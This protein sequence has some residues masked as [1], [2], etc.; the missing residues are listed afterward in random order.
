[1]PLSLAD[2]SHRLIEAARA[3]G[4]DAA[5]AVA[6]SGSTV[7]VDVRG[8]ALEEAQRSEQIDIGLRAFVGQKQASV[9][10][11]DTSERTI[12]EL[13]ARVVAMASEAPEDP[14]AGL[15]LPSQLA[16]NIDQSSLD[17]VDKAPEPDPSWLEEQAR[18]AEHAALAQRGVSQVQSA[19]AQYGHRQMHLA[20]T[21]GF[22]A[23][24][25]RTATTIS[26]VA[27]SGSGTGMERDY[28]Y[29]SRCHLEDL[30]S[31]SVI[32]TLAGQ[33]AVALIGSRKP[34][35]GTFPVLFDERISS[36][37]IG[38]LLQAS[39]GAAIA[40]GSS[41]LLGK[42]GQQVLPEGIDLIE[43]PHRLRIAGS[44]LFDG[45]GL[46]TVRRKI[47]D[48]GVLTGWALDLAT[49][50]KLGL[51]S[52]G[53]A[54][55]G[56]AG[57]PSPSVGHVELTQGKK[58]PSDLMRDMGEGLLITSMI[59]S[60]INP[61]TGDYSRGASGFWIENGEIAY[62]VNECTVAGNLNDMLARIIPSNDAQG[63]LSR[64]VP[65]ILIDGMSLAGA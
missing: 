55:R 8:G 32:G 52:T 21:N 57:G 31:A 49:A 28:D 43:N 4:A 2:L 44:R 47:I 59:G 46:P 19:S 35:T 65:S 24:S 42:A 10:A 62:P 39:N 1:M 6:I 12:V 53:N 48:N 9:S 38:H 61:N 56:A 36:S 5:D 34:R 22:S 25:A 33:R 11:S 63:H 64:V 18:I 60:T 45:E 50:R 27:I 3:A 13:A 29:D 17:L 41:W 54:T 26:C 40:R 15:A 30:R 14:H 23:G 58:S 20:A 51:E 37:L 16:T 7:S